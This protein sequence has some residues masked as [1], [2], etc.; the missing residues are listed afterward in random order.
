MAD[1]E[2]VPNKN[3]KHKYACTHVFSELTALCP[4]TRLPDF[5]EVRLTYE[6]DA[7]L[8]ELKSLK[9]YYVSFRNVEILHEEITNRILDDFI[10]AVS[11]RWILITVNV[12]NRGGVFTTVARKWKRSVGDIGL[13]SAV[14]MND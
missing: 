8:V 13:E 1:L 3:R 9:L 2:T 12:N 5:Y 6:P 11:P 4:I 10:Y 14:S 7:K